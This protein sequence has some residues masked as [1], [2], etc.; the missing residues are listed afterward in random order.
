VAH[1]PPGLAVVPSGHAVSDVALWRVEPTRDYLSQ[2]TPRTI[3]SPEAYERA[4]LLYRLLI[5]WD[6]VHRR[7]ESVEIL[8]DRTAKRRV[9]LDLTIPAAAPGTSTL[10]GIPLTLL[11][12][13][14]LRGFNLW[15]AGED[16][17]LPLLERPANGELA[18]DTLIHVA[19]LVLG[20]RALP[21]TMVACMRIV[22][23]YGEEAAQQ[24]VASWERKAA[25]ATDRYARAWERLVG[26][27]AFMDFA[28]SLAGQF[29]LTARTDLTP[30]VRRILKYEYEEELE[31][32]RSRPMLRTAVTLGWAPEALRFDAPSVSRAASWHFEA[33]A[34]EEM[35]I[36]LA[37]LDYLAAPEHAGQ[38]VVHRT[39][40]DT[41]SQ[42]RAHLY[43]AE[44]DAL[45]GRAII[46][47]RMQRSGFLNAAVLNAALVTVLLAF[48][49]RGLEALS[50]PQQGQLA[51]PLLLIVPTVIAAFIVRPQE[52]GLATRLLKGVRLLLL[53]TVGCSIAAAGMLA[54]N[55]EDDQ[56]QRL[57]DIDLYVAAFAT[58]ML[59]GSRLGGGRPIPVA[60]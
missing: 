3:L 39:T 37:T 53:V 27:G 38:D 31:I 19:E 29:I 26:S 49:A 13:E 58:L 18:T 23:E 41:G 9:T 47:M 56:L 17:R 50:D 4:S 34:P 57:W 2:R 28:R 11:N 15:E 1:A 33:K 59:I 36:V 22:A 12:K 43:C 8:D 52:H 24:Q 46:F 16:S 35:D 40:A 10:P 20:E 60:E 30:G 54:L 51:G 21:L 48:G 7:T 5:D 32:T 45:S 42:S 6:W 44:D 25:D 55:L 14:P